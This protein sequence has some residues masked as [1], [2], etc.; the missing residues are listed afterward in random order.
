MCLG[1]ALTQNRLNFVMGPY[2]HTFHFPFPKLC[3]EVFDRR[4][5]LYGHMERPHI[6]DALL[7]KQWKQAE[8]GVPHPEI[9]VE[10]DWQ[11]H[12]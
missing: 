2:L 8:L 10:L 6:G 12:C 5:K 3:S 1:R 7:H 9:Q 4:F 11:L